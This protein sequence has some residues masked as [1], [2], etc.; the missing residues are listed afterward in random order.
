MNTVDTIPENK[1][2]ICEKHGEYELTFQPWP[3]GGKWMVFED[4]PECKR[5]EQE[6]ADKL[7]EQ[8]RIEQEAKDLIARKQ[9]AGLKARHFDCTLDNY[10]ARTDSQKQALGRVR[11]FAANALRGVSGNLI[12]TGRVGT[13]KTHLAAAV[14]SMFCEHK[15]PCEI[16]KMSEMIR[17]IKDT[18]VRGSERTETQVIQHYSRLNLLVIDE[19]GIQFGSDTE[20][21]MISEVIDN[22]YQERLPTVLISNL[23]TSGIRECIG[24]RCFDRLR[25]DGGKLVAFDWE[26]ARGQR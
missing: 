5:I 24:D 9:R 12:L 23:S 11:E 25:E 26:S 6:A 10:Q 19:V 1:T 16:V 17:A 7:A 13:G 8:E 21:L 15:T 2:A 20:K 18:W 4:C 14:V 3:M 22:R